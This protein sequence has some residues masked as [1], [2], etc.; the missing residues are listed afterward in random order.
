MV[1][2]IKAT[3]G[4]MTRNELH[5]QLLQSQPNIYDWPKSM[6]YFSHKKLVL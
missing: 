2:P 5:I 6:N 4:A 1:D 3:R